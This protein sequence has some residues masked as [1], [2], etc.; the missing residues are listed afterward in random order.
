MTI[1]VAS[2]VQPLSQFAEGFLDQ[3]VTYG[4]ADIYY[5]G[6]PSGKPT[7]TVQNIQEMA[8]TWYQKFDGSDAS[9]AGINLADEHDMLTELGLTWKDLGTNLAMVIDTI[10][11]NGVPILLTAPERVL[12]DVTLGRVPYDWNYASYNHCIVVCGL[13]DNGNLMVRDY[14]NLLAEPG[15]AREYAASYIAGNIISATAVTPRWKQMEAAIAAMWNAVVDVPYDTGIAL[16]WAEKT[17]S[18]DFYGPPLG[19][20]L[21][22]TDWNGK[23]LTAQIFAG[24]WCEWQ[25]G[26]AIWRRYQKGG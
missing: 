5:S 18:E 10:K 4:A 7:G 11:S 19:K 24:G 13:Y 8:D 15:S 17:A 25:N 2:F 21:P 12:F 14:A 23:P 16:E 9:T 6:P 20:E 3:C 1:N 26:K 22:N